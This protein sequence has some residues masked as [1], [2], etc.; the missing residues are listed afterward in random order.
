MIYLKFPNPY[1]YY[2]ISLPTKLSLEESIRTHFIPRK[3]KG[4][5]I[6]IFITKKVH[7]HYDPQL[8]C[9]Q[10][11]FQLYIYTRITT[12]H[13]IYHIFSTNKVENY[14]AL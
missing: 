13:I 2:A 10:L 6:H 7:Q 3:R 4:H 12:S 1:I 5:H 9:C 14:T 8:T 11:H